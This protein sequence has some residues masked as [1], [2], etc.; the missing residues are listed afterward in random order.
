MTNP[1]T[2]INDQFPR[3]DWPVLPTVYK[4]AY[5]AVDSMIQ[6]TPI[7]NVKSAED[8]KGRFISYAVDY[9]LERAIKNGSLNC[10]YNWK[11]YS[12][13]TGRYLELIF[14]HSTASVSQ[15]ADPNRQPRNVVF[16]ENARLRNQNFLPFAEF[17]N[18]VY[19]SGLPHFLLLHGHQTLDF[20]HLGVPSST[21]K[22]KYTWLSPNL[23]AMPHEQPLSEEI[24]PQEDTDFDLDELELLKEDIEKWI[25]DND[26]GN[27]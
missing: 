11:D 23:M 1:E 25:R 13:P 17:E 15:V 12:K 5:A 22:I 24:A 14:S 21:S 6:D 9:G 3:K 7:M 10:D 27:S 2:F 16:R 19:I 4:T 18:D 8:N 20:A 26:D